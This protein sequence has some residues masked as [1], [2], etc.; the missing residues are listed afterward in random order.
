MRNLF[1]LKQ[2]ISLHKTLDN[3]ATG[4]SIKLVRWTG[5]ST[6]YIHPKHLIFSRDHFWYTDYLQPDDHVL[7][8]GCGNGMHTLKAAEYCRTIIGIDYNADSLDCALRL[9][10]GQEQKNVMF[11]KINL[12]EEPLPFAH[13]SF[14]KVL[15]LDTLEHLREREKVLREIKRVL[16]RGG[17]LLLS[18]PNRETSW[19]GMQEKAGISSYADPDHKIE[20]SRAELMEE[21]ITAGFRLSGEPIPVVYD[22]PFAGWIDLIGGLSLTIYS[23]LLRWK[24]EYVKRNP[25]ETTGWRVIAGVANS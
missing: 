20:Y 23:S 4:L 8:V 10:K 22:T 3:H 19:K 21:L 9:A 13:S 2:I 6:E 24:R 25:G 5:K 1:V 14:D 11:R 7:D 16:K 18:A 17:M 15:F 12:E